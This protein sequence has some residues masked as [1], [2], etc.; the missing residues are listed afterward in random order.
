MLKDALK[1]M[2]VVDMGQYIPGPFATLLLTDLGAEVV[3]VE[4][5]L[6]D[7]MRVFGPLDPDGISPLYKVL[8]AG[9]TVVT[10]DLKAEDGKDQL[11][12]L[13]RKSHILVESFRPGV[14]DRLG[15]GASTL[16]VLNK[17]L[18]HVMLS[19]F[20]QTGPWRL[21]AGHDLTYLALTGSLAMQGTEDRPVM[22]FPPA[23]D[24]AGALMA[25]IAVLSG[26]L[27]RLRTGRGAHLDVSLHES[28]LALNGLGLA[29]G[30]RDVDTGRCRDLLNGGAAYY[31]IYRV[32]DGGFLAFAPIEPKFWAAFCGAVGRPDLLHRQADPL[33]QE[34]L[35]AE[36]ESLFSTKSR[37][38]WVA[39][40]EPADCCVEP[41][42]DPR[43]VP[44]LPQVRERGLSPMGAAGV[45]DPLLPILLAESPPAPRSAM[46]LSDVEDVITAWSR[47]E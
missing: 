28:A 9:K 8:N 36:L 30:S 20:G 27:R 19:G 4:P 1:G 2:H 45:V 11:A 26:L 29:L 6:G 33:P 31:G 18:T 22:P 10:V 46:R 47:R 17:S 34:A 13:I 40:L 44:N 35:K 39:L 41:V 7:P 25:V 37:D 21:K 15:F 16:D 5:P 43:E 38:E 24:H 14:L 32:K 3:K 23:A 12:R 42:L